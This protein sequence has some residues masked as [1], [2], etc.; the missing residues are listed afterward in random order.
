MATCEDELVINL[1]VVSVL[2]AI[3]SERNLV[4]TLIAHLKTKTV[5]LLLFSENQTGRE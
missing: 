3:L 4:K 2:E 5:G 1:L